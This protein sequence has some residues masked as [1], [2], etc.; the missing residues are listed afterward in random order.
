MT[1]VDFLPCLAVPRRPC[2]P[3]GLTGVGVGSLCCWHSHMTPENQKCGLLS[4][5]S[6]RAVPALCS[7]VLM[8]AVIS[9]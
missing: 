4:E 9:D 2:L 6:L 7:A 3:V 8:D 1:E 5:E